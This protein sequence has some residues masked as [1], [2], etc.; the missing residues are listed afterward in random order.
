MQIQI[1]HLMNIQAPRSNYA[2]K[3][4]APRDIVGQMRDGYEVV[5]HPSNSG[6]WWWKDTQTGNWEKWQ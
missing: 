5:E 6:Q 3:I 2:Q 1:R 4:N